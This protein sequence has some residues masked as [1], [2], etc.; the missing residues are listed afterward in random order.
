[1]EKLGIDPLLILVQIVN[2]VLLLVILKKV[3]YKPILSAMKIR[4]RELEDSEKRAVETE[5]AKE[6]LER[7][8]R[9]TLVRMQKEGNNIIAAAKRDAEAERKKI[10]EKANRQAKEIV[11]G[12]K[13]QLARDLNQSS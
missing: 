13:K 5:K 6:E 3:L 11:V 9:E 8:K 1:M 7:E 2:F 10:L 4:Q 12:A